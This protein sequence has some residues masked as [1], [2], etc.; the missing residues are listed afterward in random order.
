M[1]WLINKTV[2]LEY[3]P[4]SKMLDLEAFK[5]SSI[6][7]SP[8]FLFPRPLPRLM[9]LWREIFLETSG[10]SSLD[11]PGDFSKVL[12]AKIQQKQLKIVT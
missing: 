10:N 1:H 11:K 5:A 7:A 8:A 2:S 12:E 4:P 9:E 3:Q 6:N